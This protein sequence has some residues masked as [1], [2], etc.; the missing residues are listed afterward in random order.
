MS[1]FKSLLGIVAG[2]E[3][4]IVAGNFSWVVVEI[5][6]GDFCWGRFRMSFAIIDGWGM[7]H[8]QL[9]PHIT[10]QTHTGFLTVAY[11]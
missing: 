7:V 5:V 6:V 11:L 1:Y 8:G 10:P 3:V 4:Q 9:I 2:V